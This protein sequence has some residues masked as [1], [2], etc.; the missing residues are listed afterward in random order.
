MNEPLNLTLSAAAVEA[1]A[2][3]AAEIVVEQL[4]TDGGSPSLETRTR[5]SEASDA[6]AEHE[7]GRKGRRAAF[8][9]QSPTSSSSSTSARGRTPPPGRGRRHGG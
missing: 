9:R 2:E 8:W 5:Y 4:G 1:I 7:R 6:D 3:R